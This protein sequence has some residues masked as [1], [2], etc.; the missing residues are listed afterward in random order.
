MRVPASAVA[1][2][3]RV[4]A[5]LREGR[6]AD[7]LGVAPVEVCPRVDERH[8]GLH[9]VAA[10]R[11]DHSVPQLRPAVAAQREAD[12][13]RLAGVEGAARG[14]GGQQRAHGGGSRRWGGSCAAWAV[15]AAHRRARQA[16]SSRLSPHPTL[17][18][19]ELVLAANAQ[20]SARAQPRA[21]GCNG[22]RWCLTVSNFRRF[23]P[24]MPPAG[25]LRRGPST[26]ERADAC[27]LGSLGLSQLVLRPMMMVLTV[28]YPNIPFY[29]ILFYWFSGEVAGNWI[30]FFCRALSRRGVVGASN[31][32][33]PELA[34]VGGWCPQLARPPS[35]P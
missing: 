31:V 7:H 30:E 28:H 22:I 32:A 33:R 8:H 17:S 16:S 1:S 9:R 14:R 2:P 15:A 19:G 21:Y 10:D 26:S 23:T 27:S 3:V 6:A 11:G 29:S 4:R 20:G 12:S 18:R 5:G 24:R 35:D 13:R 34:R 25:P